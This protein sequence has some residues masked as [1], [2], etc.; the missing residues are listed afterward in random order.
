[1]SASVSP[2]PRDPD[3][4]DAAVPVGLRRVQDA[5]ADGL[6]AL[7]G[8]AYDE[9]PG[10][11]LDLPGIDDDLLAPGTV[12]AQRGSSWWVVERA[13]V[14]R[15]PADGGGPAK[16]IAT[17]GCSGVGGDGIAELKR[18]Y[19]ARAARGRGIATQLIDLVERHAA[20]LGAEWVELWSDTR[21][22]DAHRRYT[23]LDYERTGEDRR[24]EDPS[25]T[26][27][28]RFVKRIGP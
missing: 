22:A 10:C 20:D 5:D 23:A 2:G 4:G 28:W 17:I 26:T 27:E 18:L 12:A 9:Y 21:F 15:A 13:P 6:I 25:D 19:V 24:L 16:V 14:E 3:L 8:A 7:I 1:V 11:V